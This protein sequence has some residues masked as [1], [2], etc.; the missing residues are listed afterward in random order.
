MASQEIYIKE[1]VEFHI[2]GQ[3]FIWEGNKISNISNNQHHNLNNPAIG[4]L[5]FFIKSNGSSI[6]LILTE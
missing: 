1:N 5:L 4:K 6:N 2:D 3:K